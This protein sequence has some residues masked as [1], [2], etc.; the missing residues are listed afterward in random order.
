MST[1][2]GPPLGRGENLIATQR[3]S[4]STISRDRFEPVAAN[5]GGQLGSAIILFNDY[6]IGF[7]RP[8]RTAAFVN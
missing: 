1:A 2:S 7:R 6:R 4:A 3:L 5:G 8:R